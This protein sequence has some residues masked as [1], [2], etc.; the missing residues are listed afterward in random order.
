[1]A[2][3][4]AFHLVL[5]LLASLLSMVFLYGCVPSDQSPPR[6]GT[7][8]NAQA[9]GEPDALTELVYGLTLSPTGIDPHINASSELGIP[10]RSVYDTL[11]YR[12]AETLEFVP[13]LAESWVISPDGLTYSFTLRQGIS[14]HD[15]TPFDAEAIR[16]NIERILNP[17]NNSLKAAQLLG[18]LAQVNVIDPY[19]VDLVLSEPFAPLLDGLSQPY[20]G[21]ASPAALAEYDAATYQFHQVGT[22]PYR[23]AEYLPNDRLVLNGIPLMRGA[24]LWCQIQAHRR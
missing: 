1:V 2:D 3:R 13:G 7:T 14:F 5:R 24:L 16:V 4:P 23:F 18:P 19:H 10:L 6:E 17:A 11:V 22:G 21:I 20:V 9:D 15:G 12:E 8:D